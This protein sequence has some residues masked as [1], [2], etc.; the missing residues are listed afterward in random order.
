MHHLKNLVI[1]PL[2]IAAYPVLALLAYN[3]EEVE[4]G[5][6]IRALA[7]CLA[8]AT[9]L[10][11]IC[12]WIIRDRDKAGLVISITLILFFSYGHVYAAIERLNSSGMPLGRHRLLIPLFVI[13]WALLIWWIL[14]RKGTLR[15]VTQTFNLIAAIA[16]LFPLVSLGAYLVNVSDSPI[17]AANSQFQAQSQEEMITNQ[18]EKPD[19][20]YIILDGYSRDD[21]LLEHFEYDN[22]GF[23]IELEALDFFVAR[24]SQSNYAHTQLSIASSLNMDFVQALD[25]DYNDPNNQSRANLPVFIHNS[26]ARAFL[27]RLGYQSVSFDSGFFWTSID[28]ADVYLEPGGRSAKYFG[29]LSGTNDFED[30]L[31]KTS[32]GLFLTDASVKIPEFLNI[33]NSRRRIHRQ[34]VLFTLDQLTQIPDL[35]G[36]KFVFAHIVS[37]HAPFV[38]GP[39][40]EVVPADIDTQE[41]YRNQVIFLNSQIIPVLKQIIKKSDPPPIIILQA[42]HGGSDLDPTNRMRILNA[43]YLPGSGDHQLYDSISPVNSFRLIFNQYFN[44]GYPL[45]TDTSYYSSY[46][47]PYD[48]TILPETGEG[49][50]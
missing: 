36:H 7:L 41:G 49:C 39:E 30:M 48:F 19:I 3:I 34:R 16:L 31:L 32:G 13:G 18:G 23:L 15:L 26:T 45:L 33:E 8:A 22:T 14:R 27:S 40:G 28:D 25:P 29:I 2:L 17:A 21:A 11:W 6:A 9:L 4:A 38:F 43:Y 24:C 5:T 1:H 37:P 46:K 42:D 35:P 44:A 50:K 10:Y 20:Y 12:R 47:R